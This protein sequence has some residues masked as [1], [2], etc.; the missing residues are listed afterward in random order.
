MFWEVHVLGCHPTDLASGIIHSQ[1][2]ATCPI[3]KFHVFGNINYHIGKT[4]INLW[5]FAVCLKRWC[6]LTLEPSCQKRS[7][8]YTCLALCGVCPNYVIDFSCNQR[9]LWLPI[10][11]QFAE[12][13]WMRTRFSMLISASAQKPLAILVSDCFQ[14]PWDRPGI[15]LCC[16]CNTKTKTKTTDATTRS[17]MFKNNPIAFQALWWMWNQR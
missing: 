7:D 10:R 12:E 16:I 6:L 5:V 11:S 3:D 4:S 8:L 15:L 2:D 17:I 9:V 1:Q 14:A 13:D